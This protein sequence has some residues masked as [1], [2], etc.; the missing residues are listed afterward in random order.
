MPMIQAQTPTDFGTTGETNTNPDDSAAPIDNYLL[1][2]FIAG[3]G[4]GYIKLRTQL[5]RPLTL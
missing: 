1:F 2:L 5:K 4:F 3:A